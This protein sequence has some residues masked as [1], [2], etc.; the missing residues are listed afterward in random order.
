MRVLIP[1]IGVLFLTFTSARNA[2]I[3]ADFTQK[4]TKVVKAEK[5]RVV[6]WMG[7]DNRIP[8]ELL[9]HIYDE[10]HKHAFPEL[11]I[12]IAKVESDFDPGAVSR[13]GAAGLTQVMAEVWE[14]ELKEK[15][16]ISNVQDLFDVSRCMAS[17]AYILQKYL[18]WEEG[19][20]RNAL[21]RYVGSRT[22]TE[23]H[24]KV[25]AA[26]AEIRVTKYRVNEL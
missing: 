22:E 9:A 25:L 8:A 17:S 10:A 15:G 3:E 4:E 7:K 18:R 11:L 5:A 21:K 26:L 1:F 13:K 19:N 6:D 14:E 23:Y 16:L 20:L 12:A 24:E 2:N